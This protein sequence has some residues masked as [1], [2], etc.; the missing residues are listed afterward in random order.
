M[1]KR[2]AVWIHGGIGTGHFSQGYPMLEK[3]LIGLSASYEVI[4]YSQFCVN[5]DYQSSNFI[6]RSAPAKVKSV[7]FRWL[8][9][10]IY[11]LKDHRHNK[12]HLLLAF[13]GYPAGL[14]ATCLSKMVGIPCAVY[15][16]GSD[17]AGIA[18][19][20]FGVLHKPILR[21]LV[22]WAYRHTN[23]LLLLS[24]FQK[25][26]LL[27]YGI[28]KAIVIPWGADKE[29]YPFKPKKRGPTLRII[30]VGHLSA[31]KDQSTL[32]RAFVL[33][34]KLHPA[35]L[36]IFGEDLLN[37]SIEKLSVELDVEKQV[38]FLGIV[39]YHQMPE[40]YAWA[41]MML[42]TSL[43]EG[44]SMALTE[45]AA[46]GVLLAGT[47]VGLL[48]DLGEDGGV[49]VEVGD[50]EGLAMCV[51]H[52]LDDEKSWDQKIQV[53]RKWAESNDLNWTIDQLKLQLNILLKDRF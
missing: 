18:S 28:T 24:E 42:H 23:L 8:Y 39:P 2:M 1:K 14:I 7:V 46:S 31:V 13:W 45:A 38:Q 19:I 11:F 15:L 3:L 6:I 49:T 37:G 32:V 53:A 9:L 16:L 30:H 33:I 43:S 26:E 5:K 4:I 50:Y 51:L 29:M 35:E 21:R 25:H 22:L 10:I 20:N 27:R 17:A 47:N 48:Y 34:A 40:Q 52:I 44:Q 36:K 41:D 12:F